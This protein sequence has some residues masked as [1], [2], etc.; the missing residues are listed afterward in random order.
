MKPQCLV[1]LLLVN[2]VSISSLEADEPRPHVV[3]LI[4][5]REYQTEL[6]LP[7]FASDHLGAYRVTFVYEDPSDKNRFS[8]IEA[9]ESADIL[10]VSV[11][12]RTL[13]EKQLDVVRRYV[14]AGKPVVGIR[15][16]SHAFCLRNQDPPKGRAGW[17]EF[18]AEVFGGAY[19]NHYGNELKATIATVKN[20]AE[21]DPLLAG[22][23]SKQ[24]F[25]AGGSLYRVSPVDEKANVLLEGRVRGEAP[26]PAAWTF[27]RKDG[28]KSFYTSLGHVD[29]F[30]GKLLP[31]LLVNALNWCRQG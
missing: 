14:A 16:A 23:D 2:A 28:G 1:L 18:D 22:L 8:G 27:T 29:D 30:R 5:E 15:T 24:S 21:D 7:K 4:A 31:R 10:L 26:E 9:I 6:S 19:T 13:P 17:P 11:R 25:V 12:R 3:M 20:A